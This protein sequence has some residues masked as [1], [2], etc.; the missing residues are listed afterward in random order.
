MSNVFIIGDS[1]LK[2]SS[3]VSRKDDYPTAILHKFEY[4]A[5]ISKSVKCN[6]FIL[7]GDVFDAPVTS[8]PYLATVINT[9]KKISSYGITVYTIV[10]NHDI[11]NNRMDSLSTTALGILISTGYVK[12]APEALTIDNT[13]FKCFNYPDDVK[14][15]TDD[16]KY[17]V[18]I[19]HRYY[20][21]ELGDGFD[22]LSSDDV[23]NL[24]YDAMVLGHYHAPCDTIDVGNT[25]LYR[26]GSL[27]R[28]TSEPYNKLRTPRALLFNCE[29]HKTVY[30]EI[31]C[32]SADEVFV[33]KIEGNNQEMIS[34]H[35][36]INFITTSYNS[37][38]MDVREYFCKLNIPCECRKFISKYLDS[39]GA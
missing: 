7:L 26:P 11:R 24:G 27:S 12:L 2:A 8:L 1:H 21:F 17:S 36:L 10:G 15:S 18:C 3:P 16:G 6:T 35:D 13:V 22:S 33:N 4:L 9:F 38:D 39:I 37:T 28:C 30:V 14:K 23:I 32:G 20:E 31:S 25:V 34:M 5:G 19:A 29:N